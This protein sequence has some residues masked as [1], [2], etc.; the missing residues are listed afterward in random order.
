MP[1]QDLQ[2][3]VLDFKK[4]LKSSQAWVLDVRETQEWNLCRLPGAY[5]IPLNQLLRRM[6]EV[7]LDKMVI[8][9]C[10]HGYRSMQ[11]VMLLRAQGY[12]NVKNLTG[13]ID[14]W[15]KLVDNSVKMY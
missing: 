11:A 10:H 13:G 1:S 3:S 14:A 4:L 12:E 2:I 8:V 5:H 6:S 15:A 7:P 9:Y